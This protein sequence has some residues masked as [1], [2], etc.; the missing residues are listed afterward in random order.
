M[1][2]T[3][4]L[5]ARTHMHNDNDMYREAF[6]TETN[7][8]HSKIRELEGSVHGLRAELEAAAATMLEAERASADGQ[9]ESAFE[10]CVVC[11]YIYA[12]VYRCLCACTF[13]SLLRINV[14]VCPFAFGC[15]CVCMFIV[16]HKGP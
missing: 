11:M 15:I 6:T 10:S 12:H 16:P 9:A 14:C 7:S 3:A 1:Q 2:A 13:G 8:L 5:C 4:G